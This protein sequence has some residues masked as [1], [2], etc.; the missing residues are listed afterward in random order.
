MQLNYGLY[1]GL[2]FS[3]LKTVRLYEA[4]VDSLK[5]FAMNL[6]TLEI[7]IVKNWYK[8]DLPGDRNCKVM[9]QK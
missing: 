6:F 3:D 2:I 4:N 9:V 1:F 5:T 8:D 7:K